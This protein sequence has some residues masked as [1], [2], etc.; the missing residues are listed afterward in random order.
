MYSRTLASYS[1]GIAGTRINVSV[2]TCISSADH[3]DLDSRFVPLST[4]H[5]ASQHQYPRTRH[6][7][8]CAPLESAGA[9]CWQDVPRRHIPKPH[10]QVS[11]PSPRAHPAQAVAADMR[12]PRPSGPP[13]A[14]QRRAI[15]VVVRKE[16]GRSATTLM[17]R[18]RPPSEPEQLECGALPVE[19]PA[20]A[21]CEARRSAGWS[22]RHNAVPGSSRCGAPT[23]ATIGSRTNRCLDTFILSPA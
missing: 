19:C 4:S 22:F 13:L 1:P 12:Q 2:H 8:Y 16:A 18:R 5:A 15:S 3:S 10:W 21:L 14:P 6:L 20:S 17:T 23:A 7:F 11:P 9:C